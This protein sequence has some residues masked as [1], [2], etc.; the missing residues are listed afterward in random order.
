MLKKKAKESDDIKWI[1]ERI[2]QIE[3]GI[4]DLLNRVVK[5]DSDMLSK[6]NKLEQKH[7]TIR[8][9]ANLIQHQFN[10]HKRDAE[11]TKQAE[12]IEQRQYRGRQQ[13]INAKVEK[14]EVLVA[15]VQELEAKLTNIEAKLN[16]HVEK[17]NSNSS[18]P[19]NVVVIK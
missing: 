14:I 18:L 17:D 2:H 15:K 7:D 1:L 3:Q 12:S 11:E 13:L 4:I 16:S 5:V 6:T 19:F 8:E 9:F 10:T